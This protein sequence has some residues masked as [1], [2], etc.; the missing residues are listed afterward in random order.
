MLRDTAHLRF[1][2]AHKQRS[3]RAM[4]QFLLR[5]P[6]YLFG[7][8]R[9]ITSATWKTWPKLLKDGAKIGKISFF[10]HNF[11][12]ASQLER[13]RC[14]AC[15]FMVMTPEGPI[16]M[17]VHNAKRDQYLLVPARVQQ[18]HK[19]LFFNPVSGK[20]ED[21]LPEKLEVQLS[22]KTAR[23]RAKHLVNGKAV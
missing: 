11:M 22:R 8:A 17:C 20:L 18:E 21:K 3:V 1:E 10:V 12:D 16:S 23:G 13:E 7:F 19:L 5:N 6:K 2:R 15:S 14:E 9:R 4:G